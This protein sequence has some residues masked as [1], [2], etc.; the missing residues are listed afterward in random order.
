MLPRTSFNEY[1]FKVL[2]IGETSTG[3]T[4]FIKQYVDQYFS[5]SYKAT[6]G[7]DFA[8]KTIQLNENTLVRLQL[9]DVAGQERF[10]TMTRAYYK[11]ALGA[12]IVFDLERA[13]TLESVIKWKNDL[14][15]KVSL[16]DGSCIP[17][18]LLANKCDLVR[19]SDQDER[20]LQE[21][22][23]KN[24][25]IGCMK[26]SPKDNINISNSVFMLVKEILKHQHTL[27]NDDETDHETISNLRHPENPKSNSCCGKQ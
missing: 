7:I 14:D 25:F 1:L 19:L 11:G 23:K 21:F 13:H 12:F 4:S 5:R 22:A 27:N 10:G 20:T 2:V 17:C 16:S 8:L 24:G 15:S 26:T 6:V 18:I 9:W 3:K